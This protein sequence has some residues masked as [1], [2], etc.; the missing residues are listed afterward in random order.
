[1]IHLCSHHKPKVWTGAGLRIRPHA[2]EGLGPPED[3]CEMSLVGFLD[4]IHRL[5][6]SRLCQAAV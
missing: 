4:D 2:G 6:V 3:R 1:M 5:G